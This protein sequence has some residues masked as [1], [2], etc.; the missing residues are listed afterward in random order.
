VKFVL[1]PAR[2]SLLGSC[3]WIVRITV[4][5]EILKWAWNKG[6]GVEVN[7]YQTNRVEKE[8]KIYYRFNSIG[9]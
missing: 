3:T 4:E 7:N 6:K 5:T 8:H 1:K 2:T 9:L